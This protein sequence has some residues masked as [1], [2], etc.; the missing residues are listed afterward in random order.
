MVC[1]NYNDIMNKTEWNL[2]DIVRLDEFEKLYKTARTEIAQ[3]DDY[4]VK[5]QPNMSTED[6]AAFTYHHERC[7]EHIHRLS[8]RPEL[9]E[10]ADQKDSQA[11]KL[12]NQVKDLEVF[13]SEKVQPISL[14]L[15]GKQIAD[16]EV[17]DD[18]NAA[19]LFAANKDLEYVYT[20]SRKMGQYSLDE[21]SENILTAKDANGIR[22]ITDLR[23]MIETEL[24]YHFKPKSGKAKKIANNAELSSYTYSPD[25][26]ERE[27]AFRARFEQY[28]KN[29]DKFFVAYQAIVKDWG[30]EAKLRG[31]KSPISV[32]NVANH[33][34]DDAI[35]A[36]MEVCS[37]NTAVFQDYFRFKA[38]RLGMDKLTRFDLYAPLG[39][40]TESYTYEQAMDLVEQTFRG[41]SSGF[42]TKAKQIISENHVDSH[43]GDS[44]RGGAFCMTVAPSVTPYVLLNYAGKMRDVSTLAHELGHGVHS[45]YANKHSISAQHPNLPLAETAST[46]G[47]MILF[48]A[49]LAGSKDANTKRNLLSDKLSDSYATICRQNFIVKFEIEAHDA[50]KRGVEESELSKL[51][52]DN[53][54]EQFGDSVEVDDLFR[55]EWAYIPHIIHTPFYCYSYNFGE[56]LSMALYKRYKDEGKSFIPK[57]EAILAAGGSED[58]A[59]I[60]GSVG[61]DMASAD[62]WQ[63]SF[64][65]LKTWMDELE[66]L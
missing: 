13:F 61:I 7:V 43:P 32:R 8:A 3:F 16:K 41:F 11:I 35:T 9:M 10:A 28:D 18:K 47:E 31:F 22:V 52:L 27:A 40:S 24:V 51:W 38:Q 12:K 50:I 6:F 57:I 25:P 14:W 63:G 58:P 42:A 49:I 1:I 36:L 44:K 62:F 23:D 66:S 34:S 46:F 2:D 56:L 21:N 29:I 26:I 55:H 19:R 20:Y 33:I 48:E 37:S 17:L 30:Y 65:I 54:K 15:K 5:M 59:T 53:L 60:L 64:E 4:F 39:E 45:L